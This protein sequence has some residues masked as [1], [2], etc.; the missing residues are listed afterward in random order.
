M[1]KQHGN[2]VPLQPHKDGPSYH[3]VVATLSL[4]SH[5]VF[6]YYQYRDSEAPAPMQEVSQPANGNGRAIDPKPSASVFLEPRSLIITTSELYAGHL[7]GIDEVAEDV[8]P[9]PQET[10]GSAPQQ[11]ILNAEMLGSHAAR[12]FILHGGSMSREVRYSLTCRD[13]ERVAS[14]ALSIARR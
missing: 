11:K 2:H 7:H 9:P 5:A 1:L 6:N 4:G 10:V 8:F 13:V 14:V 12:E 3:P